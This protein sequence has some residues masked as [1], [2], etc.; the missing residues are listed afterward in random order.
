MSLVARSYVVGK[1]ANVDYPE[2]WPDLLDNVLAVIRSGTDFQLHG[3]LR[4]LSDLV[5]NSLSEAQ[6]FTA[7]K[8]IVEVLYHVALN[9][10]RRTILRALAVSVFR[11]SFDLMDMVKDDHMKEVKGFAQE[12]LQGWLPFFHDVMK[13]PFPDRE[14]GSAT[15]P[16]AWNGVVAL[17]LQ[18]VKTLI[19]IKSVFASLLLPQSFAFFE[20]TWAELSNVRAHYLEQYIRNDSQGRLEDSDG[21]PYTLDFH[22]LEELDFLNQCM[23]APP[24]QKELERQLQASGSAHETR[25]MMELMTIVVP[26]SCITQEEEEL[27]DIDVSLFLAEE[28]A[29]TANYTARTACGDLLIKLVEWIGQKA[30]EGLFAHTRTLFAAEASDWRSQEAA[31]Y[32]FNM[33]LSDLMDCDKEISHEICQ[34]YLQLVDYA[35][36]QEEQPLLQA[37]GYLVAGTMAQCFPP[38]LQ[39]LDRTIMAISQSAS[40][41]VQVACIRAVEGFVKSNE[42]SQDRQI[43]I[44]QAIDGFISSRDMS[45][46]EGA[47]DLLVTLAET[48]RAA[49][50]MNRAVT[51]TSDVKSIDLLF[52]L[53]KQGAQNFQIQM[54]INDTV[55]EIVRSLS[56]STSYAALCAKIIPTLNGFFSFSEMSKDESLVTVRR[57]RLIADRLLLSGNIYL[58]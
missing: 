33:L 27:W 43:P 26:Y 35:V 55:E 40:E 38:A 20:E 24:V 54:I 12:A 29:V 21:L 15:Q 37:R 28:A 41:L 10:N 39:V 45:D 25:W 14:P 4:V 23:R 50:G 7:A 56:D 51:V 31:L 11:S 36:A 6:F 46:L 49:I 13:M 9:T 3:A 19:K 17:K 58:C 48:L 34:V 32:L 8:G 42:V 30:L 53:A 22:V 2:N 1:I 52:T 16:A 47:D 18:V 5:D 44:I 57:S